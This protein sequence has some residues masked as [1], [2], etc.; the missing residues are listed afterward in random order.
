MDW[1]KMDR[2]QS[3]I[4]NISKL[5]KKGENRWLA[6]IGEV[7]VKEYLTQIKNSFNFSKE[8]LGY[9]EEKLLLDLLG[10]DNEPKYSGLSYYPHYG[11]YHEYNDRDYDS[12]GGDC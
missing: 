6:R 11:N 1:E 10:I 2:L 9:L 12:D 3:R 4:L 8:E 5:S 7:V